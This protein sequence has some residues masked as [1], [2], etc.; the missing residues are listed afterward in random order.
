MLELG[1]NAAC[2]VDADADL[3]DA[4][5]RMIIGAYYQS[6]QSCIGVQRILVQDAVYDAFRDRFV[7]ATKALKAGNPRDEQNF[8]GPMIS[9]KEASRLQGWVDE[10]AK[11]GGKVLCGGTTKGNM[12]QATVLE[13]VPRDSDLVREEA[14][15]PVAILSRFTDFE[16]ALAEVNDSRYGL[17]AGVFT[18]DLFKAMRAWD[19]LDVGGVLINDIPNWRVDHMPYGGV[20]DSGLGREGIRFAIEDMT[21]VRMMVIRG[22]AG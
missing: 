7:S 8:I 10:A 16:A 6:G 9:E 13:D 1:G 2:I 18:R 19:E 21:E 3:E 20:K 11:A 15:G 22:A 14:F 17:Q 4:V 5:E 12:M